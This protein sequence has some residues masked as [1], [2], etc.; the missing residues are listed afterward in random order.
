[1][2]HF[3][4]HVVSNMNEL[5]SLFMNTISKDILE[6]RDTK[7]RREER[8][9]LKILNEER[10]REIQMVIAI[11]HLLSLSSYFQAK[12]SFHCKSQEREKERKMKE[13]FKW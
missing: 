11:N 7:D 8:V 13:R 5:T 6:Q 1:M 3:V 2:N 10:T 12:L 4:I 9:I